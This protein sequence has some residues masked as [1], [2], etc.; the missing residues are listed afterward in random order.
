MKTKHCLGI[1]LLYLMII[2]HFWTIPKIGGLSRAIFES[3][4]APAPAQA[5]NI[6]CGGGPCTFGFGS[7]TVFWFLHAQ[8]LSGW[9]GIAYNLKV[10][11][12]GR[13]YLRC[14]SRFS[15]YFCQTHHRNLGKCFKTAQNDRKQLILLESPT[16]NPSAAPIRLSID[17]VPS[18]FA[19]PMLVFIIPS[20]IPTSVTTFG[21]AK[22]KIRYWFSAISDDFLLLQRRFN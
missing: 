6:R 18:R 5:W 11:V 10:W 14:P 17:R 3:E 19:S 21:H 9:C 1:I 13:V 7:L 2:Y 8:K 4:P 15:S 16:L 20:V 12:C 22:I